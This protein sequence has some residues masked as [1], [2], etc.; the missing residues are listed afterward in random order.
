MFGKKIS[1]LPY[2]IH[3]PYVSLQVQVWLERTYLSSGGENSIVRD[4]SSDPKSRSA[5]RD[6]PRPRFSKVLVF[7]LTPKPYDEMRCVVQ[8]IPKT[9]ELLT[10]PAKTNL[11]DPFCMAPPSALPRQPL[12]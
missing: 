10:L 12:P 2:G 6:G 9:N 3:S 5:E 7:K 8:M 1:V 4:L 11:P